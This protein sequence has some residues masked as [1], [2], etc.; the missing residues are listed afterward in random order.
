MTRTIEWLAIF[1]ICIVGPIASSAQTINVGTTSGLAGWTVP[2]SI[3]VAPGTS[4]PVTAQNQISYDPTKIS[5]ATLANG[6]PDCTV[7]PSTGKS[8]GFAFLPAGCAG[9]LCNKVRAIV[10]NATNTTIPSGTLYT[11][12]VKIGASVSPGTYALTNAAVQLVNGTATI[13][14]TTGSSGSVT[15]VP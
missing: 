14:G 11:C 6:S 9:N 4:T 5:I 8:A 10:W 2:V 15:V 12:K 1:G 3:T 13:V 7:S